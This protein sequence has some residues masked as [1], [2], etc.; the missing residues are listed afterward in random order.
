[1]LRLLMFVAVMVLLPNSALAWNPLKIGNTVTNKWDN[2]APE[3]SRA[4]AN[5]FSYT[6]ENNSSNDISFRLYVTD[7]NQAN[8]YIVPDNNDDAVD[9]TK[10]YY[11]QNSSNDRAFKIS[12]SGNASYTIKAQYTN[13]GS[14][15][16]WYWT[17]SVTKNSGTGNVGKAMYLQ[18]DIITGWGSKVAMTSTANND[19]TYTYSY[20][21][22]GTANYT[23]GTNVWF[24]MLYG[25]D[26][27]NLRSSGPEAATDG[28]EVPIGSTGVAATT[29]NAQNDNKNYKLILGTNSAYRFS[30]TQNAD[31]SWGNVTVTATGSERAVYYLKYGTGDKTY[32]MDQMVRNSNGVYEFP[33]PNSAYSRKNGLTFKIGLGDNTTYSGDNDK[34]TITTYWGT[35]STTEELVNSTTETKTVSEVAEENAT[36]FVISPTTDKSNVPSD[37][38]YVDFDP[39]TGTLS[40][41]WEVKASEP[42]ATPSD[43]VYIVIRHDG[44]EWVTKQLNFTRNRDLAFSTGNQGECTGVA[45]NTNYT[46]QNVNFKSDDL[47]RILGAETDDK[48]FLKAGQKIEWYFK[49]G[50]E[51]GT[52]YYYPST[53]EDMTT[54]SDNVTKVYDGQQYG[55]NN[56]MY[57]HFSNYYV[58]GNINAS[59]TEPTAYFTYTKGADDGAVSY[60]FLLN[61]AFTSTNG[62]V[63]NNNIGGFIYN[64]ALNAAPVNDAGGN[65][66]Y[67]GGYFLVGNFKNAVGTNGIS[68]TDN[69]HPMKRY[70]YY[71]GIAYYSGETN[72]NGGLDV[73]STTQWSEFNK[74]YNN[75]LTP[76]SIVFRAHVDQ[77]KEGWGALYIA[78]MRADKRNWDGGWA[79]RP[80]VNAE[81]FGNGDHGYGHSIDALALAGGLTTG[82]RNQSLNPKMSDA[83]DYLGLEDES[84]IS[85]YDFSIN[86]TTS[87]YRLI[88]NKELESTT[89]GLRDYAQVTYPLSNGSTETRTVNGRNGFRFMR[90]WYSPVSYVLTEGK[91]NLSMFIMSNVE[92]DETNKTVKITLQEI[93]FPQ[94]ENANERE[95][96]QDKYYIYAGTPL[97]LAYK[98]GDTDDYS[99]DSKFV[100]KASDSK[101][102][103]LYNI[104]VERMYTSVSLPTSYVPAPFFVGT[105]DAI[106]IE[107]SY[108]NEKGETA[109]YNYRFGFYRHNKWSNDKEADTNFDL[110]MWILQYGGGTTYANT[111]YL[112]LPA[113]YLKDY[114]WGKYLGFS[115]TMPTIAGTNAKKAPAMF[116][117]WKT[118]DNNTTGISN[119]NSEANAKEDK[120][121]TLQGVQVSRPSKQG[122]YIHN[123]KKIMV[124]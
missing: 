100:A 86:V 72:A 94:I 76:D 65:T 3:M 93:P 62:T 91:D 108:T 8:R 106:H 6:I 114:D 47:A 29:G 112:H 36:S 57:G 18:S 77:P 59:T 35:S 67:D 25:E 10:H 17:I 90:E 84:D 61:K 102:Y 56:Q 97:I 44:G 87:T 107:Q 34:R 22:S 40:S 66:A 19:G 119:A 68:A 32:T 99:S 46:F 103:N 113:D 116:F 43:K 4:D 53:T 124:K 101:E 14:G 20:D 96:N 11:A 105:A 122:I 41:H 85:S 110:G 123:G 92:R 28:L 82:N 45:S 51:P 7:D 81:S 115:Y 74:V 79:I 80:Q 31:G 54:V 5:N 60:T 42:E 70:Y 33:I 48:G 49:N 1:M 37:Y 104:P 2:S 13:G 75:T 12:N 78:V 98:A 21:W 39:T 120:W 38:I 9:P 50:L 71:K 118:L 88:F 89:I 52:T 117:N 95:G 111:A 69:S 15:N 26:N 73:P 16:D 64:T 23:A 24:R 58:D 55:N 109:G 63:V 83:V 30:I 27:E 121:Y